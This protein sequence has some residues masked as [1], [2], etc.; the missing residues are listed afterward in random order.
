MRGPLVFDGYL[1][2]PEATRQ[3]FVDGWYRTGDL[4]LF[5]EEGFLYLTGRVKEVINRGGE[6][7]SPV[8][9]DRILESH[10]A[11]AEGAAFG[12]PHPT[13]GEVVVAAVVPAA[14]A[15]PDQRVLRQYLQSHLPA[16]KV[17]KK[18]LFVD[19]LPRAENDKLRRHALRDALA[20]N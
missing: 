2:D 20:R 14:G 13:L 10:P 7:I 19:F 16:S 1:D 15:K 11:V 9:I 6:K 3:A 12:L 4:G 5:D 8:E 17:P 18:I